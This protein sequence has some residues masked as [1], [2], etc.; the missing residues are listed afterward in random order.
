M[1]Q[2]EFNP[3]KN[4]PSSNNTNERKIIP[5]GTTKESNDKEDTDKALE[6][7]IA[8]SKTL[9]SLTGRI[10]QKIFTKYL[11]DFEKNSFAD[12]VDIGLGLSIEELVARPAY[13]KALFVCIFKKAKNKM[14]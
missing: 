3:G 9:Q 5:L 14:E 6:E 2:I 13:G 7:L 10:N 1:A 8:K 11:A 4:Q 12:L